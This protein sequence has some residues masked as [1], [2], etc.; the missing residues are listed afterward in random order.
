VSDVLDK[1]STESA[2]TYLEANLV[3]EKAWHSGLA[4]YVV[5]SI[6]AAIAIVPLLAGPT[7]NERDKSVLANELAIRFA[8]AA[9]ALGTDDLSPLPVQAFEQGS[10]VAILEIPKLGMQEIVVEGSSGRDTARAVGH[11]F[12]S[13]GPG[14]EGNSVLV[15]RSISYGA[16]FRDID[17]LETGDEVIL[18][19]IQGKAKYVVDDNLE[20]PISGQMGQ[21]SDSRLTLVTASP[22]SLASSLVVVTATLKEKPFVSFPQNPAWLATHPLSPSSFPIASLI[23]ILVSVFFVGLGHK[24]L[25]KFFS[26]STVLAIFIPVFLAQSVLVARVLFDFLPPSL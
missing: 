14:Q 13:S 24:F 22:Q 19:T 12:G 25:K 8:Q 23:L 18:L 4:R 15:G 6:V 26:K 20:A 1:A 17:E 9:S 16:P 7:I 10:P 3:S 2:A 21:S 5:L 11:L